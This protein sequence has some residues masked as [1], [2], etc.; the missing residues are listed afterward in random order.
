MSLNGQAPALEASPALQRGIFLLYSDPK[1]GKTTLLLRTFPRALI[2]GRRDAILPIATGGCGFTPAPWQIIETITTLPQLN[3]FLSVEL[4]SKD[5]QAAV[6][7]YNITAIIV[8]DLS[9]LATKSVLIW[10]MEGKDSKFY[11]YNMLAQHL[12]TANYQ[13]ADLGMLAGLSAHK[14]EPRWDT[15]EKSKTYG[16]LIGLGAP[17]MPSKG[18]TQAVPGWATLVAPMRT[19]TSLDP[20]WPKVISVDPALDLWVNGDRNSIC[21]DETPAN[22]REILRAAQTRYDL[23]RLPGMEW[24]DVTAERVAVAL[25]EGEPVNDVIERMFAHYATY[26]IP[27]TPGER[28]V[29]WAVQDG[30]ARYTIRARRKLGVLA[31]LRAAAPDAPPPP[32][33]AQAGTAA[34]AA[35]ATTK[36]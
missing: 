7:A 8:D 35:A 19:G 16:K 29:Q 17:E 32:P 30:I 24:Q 34:P 15:S 23:Q 20:W 31:A 1:G 27:G 13:I 12:D 9:H 21:W 5:W 4:K 33:P 14:T 2:I 11:P 28:H 3:H 10:R 6:R 25:A 26:A 18:Q 22:L 36:G